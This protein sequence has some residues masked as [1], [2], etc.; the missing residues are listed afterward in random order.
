MAGIAVLWASSTS[1]AS[2]GA[3]SITD[4][5]VVE[6]KV[7][8]PPPTQETAV[9]GYELNSFGA[10]FKFTSSGP[11]AIPGEWMTAGASS[12]FQVRATV[13]AGS[14]PLGSATG[15]WQTMNALNAWRVERLADNNGTTTSTLLVEI[16]DAATL[17]VLDTATVTL[18]A[19]VTN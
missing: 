6:V 7:A 12:M 13:Q 9:A 8:V 5:T 15:N 19:E 1:G 11:V 17:V 14:T 18:T 16:R 4:Q 2:S 3:V 10:A